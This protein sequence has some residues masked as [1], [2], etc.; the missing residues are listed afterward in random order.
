MQQFLGKIGIAGAGIMGL[1]V[2]HALA[3]DHAVVLADVQGFPPLRCTASLMAG[4]MLAPWSEIEHMPPEFMRAAASGI[5]FWEDQPRDKT[6]FARNGSLLL[7]HPEDL[8]ILDRFASK[9][10]ALENWR[11]V[12][13][14]EIAAL[15]P[16]LAGR[17]NRGIYI[18][19]EAFVYPPQVMG[20]YA[21]DISL[22]VAENWDTNTCKNIFDWLVDC[23]GYGA[24]DDERELRGVKGEIA[25]VRNAEL[26]LNRPVR[27]MHPRYPIYIVPRPNHEYTIGATLIESADETVMVKSSMELLSAAYSLHPS[28]GEAAIVNLYAGIRPAYPDNLPRITIHENII[29]C[30]GLFRHGYLLAP[31]MAQCVADYIAGKDN[32]FMHLFI[33][34]NHDDDH[35]QR[36]E[37]K[38]R[39][40]A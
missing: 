16:A 24:A 14:E 29:R 26:V 4:G 25:V 32:E 36:T 19:E 34:G 3:R 18:P 37:K 40:A 2:A 38:L 17:F 21:Q 30:N 35:H 5:K 1:S 15:E 23:R 20:R 13:A 22:R 10:S 31:V 39:S 9:L 11:P 6:G 33:R 28:F 27:L 12:N 7:A 8:Y